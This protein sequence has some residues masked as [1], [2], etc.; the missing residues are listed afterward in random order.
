MNLE[1]IGANARQASYRLARLS[2][3]EKNALLRKMSGALFAD[4]DKILLANQTDLANYR[5]NLQDRLALTRERV[6]AMA[7]AVLDIAELADPVGEVMESFNRP[8]GLVIKKVRVPLGVIGII[9]E[10][11]PNVTVDTAALCLKSGNA[12]ILRGGKEAIN[13]N[14]ALVEIMQ[15]VLP[16]HAVQLITDTGRETAND[17]MHLHDLDVLIPRGGENLIKAVRKNAT[18]PII[19]TGTGNCHIYV[20]KSADL[21]MA[22]RIIINAKCSRPSVCNACEKVLMDREIADVFLPRITKALKDNGVTVLTDNVDWY[23]EYL[24]MKIA[25]KI[26]ENVDE[27]IAH[28]NKYSSKHSDSIITGDRK[29]SGIF[30]TQI[31]SAAVYVNASTRF[32]DGA[33]FG[34]GAELGI[35][36]QKLHARGPVGLMELTSYKY[37]IEGSG[38]IR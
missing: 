15:G 30:T 31:D 26:V 21:D 35:S 29:A 10:A 8:N 27:A 22:E 4:S 1:T 14:M 12:I 18:V 11:R 36:T 20:E 34:F 19:E 23:E 5:G 38:Q 24:D 6:E 17:F 33:E 9:Y 28:I 3:A 13:S 16:E 7:N 2:T 32:T 25:I 37:V